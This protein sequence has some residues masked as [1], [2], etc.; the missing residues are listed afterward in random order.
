MGQQHLCAESLRAGYR[1][2]AA[3]KAQAQMDLGVQLAKAPEP[4]QVVGNHPREVA[5]LGAVDLL[6]NLGF[7]ARRGMVD[8]DERHAFLVPNPLENFGEQA[9]ARGSAAAGRGRELGD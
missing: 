2:W 7:C 5:H 1:R 6:Q 4:R 9:D 3:G 8:G